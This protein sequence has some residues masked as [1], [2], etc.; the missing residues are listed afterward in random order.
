[1]ESTLVFLLLGV[2]VSFIGW[3]FLALLFFFFGKRFFRT[4]VQRLFDLVF[5]RLLNDPFEENLM[6][7]WSAVKRT[8]VQNI[9]EISLRAETGKIIKRPLGSPKPFNHY[10]N[11]LFIPAQMVRIPVEP[12]VPI[13]TSVTL[14]PKAQ[15]PLTLP[16]PLLIGGMG[17]GVALSEEAK[18]ALAK[19]SKELGTAMSSGE[20]PF[21]PEERKAAGKYIWQISRYN[22]GRDPQGI[23]TADML[24][25]QMGQGSRMGGHLINPVAIK[26]KA[27]KL[28]GISPVTTLVGSA[29]FAEIKSP[30]DWPRY[31]KELRDLRADIPIGIKIMGGGRLEAD[32]AVALEAG[33]DVICISGAG[34]GTASS[35]PTI[36]DDF[37]MPSINNL[38]RAQK[39]L[40]EQG[41]RHEVSLISAGGYATPGQCL[42][43][44]ALGAD[45]I[46]L[47]T[48]PLFALVH[49][50]LGKVMP[51]EPLTQ[52]VY[53][54][55]K[56]KSRLDIN[57]ASQNV[58]KVL[59]SFVLE[60]E[61]GVRAMG[62]KSV[63]DLGPND[64]VALDDWTAE[65]TGV[66]RAWR[67]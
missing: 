60:M 12:N 61:E 67:K 16:I 5:T 53:Y 24:E 4:V 34:G 35:S 18:I 62:K 7:F 46:Y 22:Y 55:S 40:Q 58:V 47:G 49:N 26:G 37:G 36:C 21:L 48:V 39:Y 38:V 11:L 54:N 64:M 32:L 51:W 8:S 3:L 28:M 23:A 2:V 19:A 63:K 59:T 25:V 52:L 57:M 13:D 15:K 14:G 31:V 6:E 42:K 27:Q 33:F 20:G 66:A 56:Y 65:V 41:V 10:D 44:L 45:A 29:S 1:M 17:Y 50:Q 30:R 9:L 43:A